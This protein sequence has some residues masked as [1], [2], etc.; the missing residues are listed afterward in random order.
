[1]SAK[2]EKPGKAAGAAVPALTTA[3]KKAIQ[4]ADTLIEALGWIRRF[5]DTT[6]R[7][8]AHPL[9]QIQDRGRFVE[10]GDHHR[11]QGPLSTRGHGSAQHRI[12]PYSST[13]A[14]NTT[15]FCAL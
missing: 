5:R 11:E 15:H 4:K 9:Q 2:S 7:G 6:T 8:A 10:A 12:A 13:G 1:M 14:R 3:Q